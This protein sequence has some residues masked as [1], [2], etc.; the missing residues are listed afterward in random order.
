MGIITKWQTE[1]RQVIVREFDKTWNW[2]DF[3]AS[4]DEVSQMLGSVTYKVHQILDFS[5]S[6]SLPPNALT[7][8]GKS[9]RNMPENRGATIVVMESRLY[10]AMYGILKTVFPALVTRVVLVSTREEAEAYL[11]KQRES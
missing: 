5:E 2:E 11:E 10:Q 3:Y 4:Q 9:G 8:I 6:Q 1:E 7:H